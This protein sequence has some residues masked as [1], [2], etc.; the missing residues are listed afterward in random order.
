VVAVAVKKNGVAFLILYHLIDT[1]GP[2]RTWIVTYLAPGFA[3]VYGALLLD[4]SISAA[5]VAGLVLILLG[6]WLAAGAWP[7]RGAG[8]DDRGTPNGSVG[9]P[10][11]RIHDNRSDRCATD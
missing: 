8:G 11:A 5:T 7:G 3:V 9:A 10:K 4:E 6:S 2:A 1:V